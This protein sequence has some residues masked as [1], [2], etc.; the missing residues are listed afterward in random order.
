M[1]QPSVEPLITV[2]KRVAPTFDS[3]TND[4]LR[5]DRLLAATDGR[6]CHRIASPES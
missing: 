1:R 4:G 6:M 2:V 5:T 3:E